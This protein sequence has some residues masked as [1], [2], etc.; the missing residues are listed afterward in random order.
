MSNNVTSI[1]ESAFWQCE[2]L[3]NINISN[4]ITSISETTFYGCTGLSSITIPNS[5]TSIG[6]GAFWKC[7][8][9][10]VYTDNDYAKEYCQKYHIPVK[11]LK[12]K[13]ESYKP[14]RLKIREY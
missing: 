3:K 2:S 11:S 14:F 6:E 12:S 1:S 8:N 13:N 4:S 9:L 7:K 10:T 5:V